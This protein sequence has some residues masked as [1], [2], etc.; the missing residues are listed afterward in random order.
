MQPIILKIHN[1]V[2]YINGKLDGEVYREL[3]KEIGYKPE[4]AFWMIE[5]QRQKYQNPDGTF[6]RGQEWRENWDG[7]ISTICWNKSK[8][9]CNTKKSGMHFPTGLCRKVLVF[10]KKRGVNFEIR[11]ERNKVVKSEN[12]ILSDDQ[13]EKRNYQQEVIEKALKSDRGIIKCCTGAGKTFIAASIIANRATYPIIFYVP[14][15]DLMMQ[16]KD[17]IERFVK[18]ENGDDVKVG[19]VGGGNK[20]IEEDITV[21]T[22]QTAVR[23]LGGVWVKFDKEDKNKDNTNIE[24]IKEEIK[25]IIHDSKLIICDEVQHWAA[26]TCQIISDASVSARYRYGMSATPWRDKGDDILID[27]CFGSSI[28]DI[29]ASRLIIEGYLVKPYIYWIPIHTNIR[30]NSYPKIYK[31]AI[32][33]NE[34]RNT[35]IANLV[36]NLENQGKNILILCTQIQHGNILNKKIDGSVFLKGE[37]SN[38]KRKKHLDKMRKKEKRITIAT[39]IFDEGINCK[40]LDTLILAGGGKSPT[41]TLQRIGRILRLYEGKKKALVFDFEDKC[42]I[43]NRHASQRKRIY[44]TEPEFKIEKLN[45]TKN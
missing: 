24:S 17:E 19:M 27:G 7:T 12:L 10:F 36:K 6:K 30:L 9:R 44:K 14:S 45:I 1:N 37:T 23:S 2:T 25:K 29:N 32:V 3:K 42:K 34:Y 20:N 38:K 31:D 41:R 40:S 5:N 8:C 21:M 11:D 35:I 26:E 43:L 22:I 16:A 15:V 28:V 18:K 13:I 4:N 33:R 39:S